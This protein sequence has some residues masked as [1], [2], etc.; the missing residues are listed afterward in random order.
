[1]ARETQAIAHRLQMLQNN[2]QSL[3]APIPPAPQMDK[4]TFPP[5][6]YNTL[7]LPGRTAVTGHQ[8]QGAADPL[9]PTTG[10]AEPIN[11]AQVSA[12]PAKTALHCGMP[13]P[14]EA[15]QE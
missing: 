14:G 15:S 3:S 4:N 7:P 13:Q 9:T 8:Q 10:L 1:M 11:L 2:P 6:L 12:V 5:H